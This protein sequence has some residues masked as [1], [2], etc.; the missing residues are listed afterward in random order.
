MIYICDTLCDL[1][2]HSV[3]PPPPY[4]GVGVEPPTKFSKR[5]GLTGTRLLEGGCWERG[6]VTFF[7]GEG[8]GGAAIFT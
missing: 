2:P 8:G 5:G 6:G 3:H 7:M 4:R 1:V